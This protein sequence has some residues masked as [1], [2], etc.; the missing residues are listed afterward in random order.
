MSHRSG[1]SGAKGLCLSTMT[2]SVLAI[3]ATGPHPSGTDGQ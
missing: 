1:W 3:G 2:A